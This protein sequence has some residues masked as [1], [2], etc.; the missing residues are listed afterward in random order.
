MIGQI[1]HNA[2]LWDAVPRVEFSCFIMHILTFYNTFH[3]DPV[4]TINY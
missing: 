1:K 2:L 3:I 4:L